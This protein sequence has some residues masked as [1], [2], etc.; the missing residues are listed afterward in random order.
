MKVLPP[1]LR[2]VSP[3]ELAERL[4]AERSGE[5]FLVYV[6]GG[7]RQ[8]IVRLAGRD[9][10]LS[11]G[12]GTSNDVT[13]ADDD[14]VS[15]VHAMLEPVGD[16]W[17]VVDDGLSRNGTYVNGTRV[18]GRRRLAD[19]DTI[20]IGGTQIV[21]VGAGER[22][23]TTRTARHAAPPELSAAR[24]RVLMALCRPLFEDPFA[25]PPSNR[26]IAEEL[27]VGVETVKSHMHALFELFEVE[28]MPQNRKRAELVRRAFQRGA[29]TGPE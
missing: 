8:A 25:G 1:P 4:E 20:G 27:M 18:R 17:T 21:Y 10:A 12:R 28:D 6:D 16:E 19:G 5:A 2:A 15:R 14:E 3:A 23:A 29:L 7:A 13:L 11:V 22:A 26:E 9:E 24:R